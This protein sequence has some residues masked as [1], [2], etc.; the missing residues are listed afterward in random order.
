MLKTT[1]LSARNGGFSP[2]K[3]RFLKLMRIFA[4]IKKAYRADYKHI[5]RN[6][7]NKRFSSTNGNAP[8]N[9][10]CICRQNILFVE[11]ITASG[12]SRKRQLKPDGDMMSTQN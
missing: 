10:G 12:I 6:A 8:A 11:I 7:Q 1:V 5:S 3:W 2:K 9:M 4:G